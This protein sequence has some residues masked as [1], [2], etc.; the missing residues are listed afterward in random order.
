[1]L[2][3]GDPVFTTPNK[4]TDAAWAGWVQERGLYFLGEKDPRYRDL[5]Q[6]E[7]PFPNNPGE[8]RG[9]LV[10]ATYGK[11]RWIYVGA[12]ALARAAGRRRRRVSAA[13]E[14][15]QPRRKGTDAP[16]PP[17]TGAG[18]TRAGHRDALRHVRR[19]APAR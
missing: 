9:A 16:P 5:V 6:L 8:K 17:S 18:T 13:G 7:D 3:P 10:E 19:T 2:E 11:G 14:P 4:I 15:D 1:M 12:R